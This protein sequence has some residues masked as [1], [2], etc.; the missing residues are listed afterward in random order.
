MQER[1]RQFEVEVPPADPGDRQKG[2]SE[3]EAPNKRRKQESDPDPHVP[4]DFSLCDG[5]SDQGVESA[6]DF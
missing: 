1:V 3:S 6:D 2:D 4:V 5:S